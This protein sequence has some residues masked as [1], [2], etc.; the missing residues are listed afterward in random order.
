MADDPY[1][2][3]GGS[4][5]GAGAPAPVDPY[6]KYGGSSVGQQQQQFEAG[7]QKLEG[8]APYRFASRVAENLNP[9]SAVA[10]LLTPIDTYNA[11]KDQTTGKTRE[12]LEAAKGGNYGRAALST[13]EAVPLLGNVVSGLENDIRGG[14][15]AGALGTG[16]AMAIPEGLKRIPGFHVQV[17]SSLNPVEESAVQFGQQAGVPVNLGTATGNRFVGAV[18]AMARKQPFM[19]GRAAKFTENELTSLKNVGEALI[20]S[21]GNVGDKVMAGEGVAKAGEGRINALHTEANNAYNDLRNI[22]AKNVKRIQVGMRPSSIL[23]ANGQPVMVPDFQDIQMPVSTADLK[24]VVGPIVDRL[25]ATI[26]SAQGQASPGLSVLRQIMSRP[27]YV[28]VNT[29]ISDLSAIQGI[30]RTRGELD[31]VRGLSKGLAATAVPPFRRAIDAAATDAGP[32][33]VRALAKGRTATAQKYAAAAVLDQLPDEPAQIVQRLTRKGDQGV[34]LLRGVRTVAPGELPNIGRSFLEGLLDDMTVE[35]DLRRT[36]T[37][38]NQWNKLGQET[39]DILFPDKKVQGQIGDFFKLAKMSV[40]RANP[41]ESTT[42][43]GAMVAMLH[44]KV[45]ATQ[46]FAGKPLSNLLF[47]PGGAQAAQTGFP[48]RVVPRIATP[49]G[50]GVVG[51]N[52]VFNPPPPPPGQ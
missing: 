48:V 18:Q 24:R 41:S 42:T 33:A 34:Q 9:I 35:G 14:N 15:Y 20:D 29:A 45:I 6:A 38:L 22:A 12:A 36:G 30:A 1:A 7:V 39:K 21:T 52:T 3:Y 47:G 19:A 23:D 8:G 28:D 10:P 4:A 2:K 25:D 17:P 5:V 49:I 26:P 32:D 31:A 51:A 11:I 46:L 50:R 16:A 37:A 13:V 44:P 43:F 27:D 40:E